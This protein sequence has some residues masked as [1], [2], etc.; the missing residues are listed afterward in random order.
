MKRA[1]VSAAKQNRFNKQRM[2]RANPHSL[3]RSSCDAC[4]GFSSLLPCPFSASFDVSCLHLTPGCCVAVPAGTDAVRRDAAPRILS[5]GP[6]FLDSR[7]FLT[8]WGHALQL[9]VAGFLRI[10]VVV[11]RATCCSACC[12]RRRSASCPRYSIQLRAREPF[13]AVRIVVLRLARA[14]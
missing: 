8:P 3:L 1:Y 10:L 9:T 2:V 5:A 14:C 11:F 12:C 13:P 7:K 6:L 4:L